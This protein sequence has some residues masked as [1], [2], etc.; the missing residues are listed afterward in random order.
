MRVMK[1]IL[2][3]EVKGYST[4]ALLL[5]DK[6]TLLTLIFQQGTQQREVTQWTG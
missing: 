3:R 5:Y 2:P 1:Y 6:W 4:D